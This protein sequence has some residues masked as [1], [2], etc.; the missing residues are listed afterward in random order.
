MRTRRYELLMLKNTCAIA[1]PAMAVLIIL[2]FMLSRYPL[3]DRTRCVEIGNIDNLNKRLSELYIDG[4]TNVS[5]TA[6]ELKYTG[7]N[8]LEDGK[9]KA[10]YYYYVE[11]G[12]LLVMLVNTDKPEA[13]IKNKTVK[14]KIIK[15][16]VVTS[17][18]MNEYAV[19]ND[20]DY[21]LL[22]E[23]CS[24]YVISEPNY[25]YLFSWMLYVIVVSPIIV[26]V[27]ILCYTLV[28][29]FNP[30]FNSQ[31]NQLAVYGE[32]EDIIE[33]L[34]A[35]MT[36]ALKLKKSNVYVTTDYMIVSYLTKTEVIKLDYIKFLSKNIVEKKI[37]LKT[38]EIYRLTMSD[39]EKLFFEVDFGSEELIDAVVESIRGIGD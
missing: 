15:D 11:D 30:R 38:K 31:T 33:D 17:H 25:P 24:E 36:N 22:K 34:N 6:N 18:I 27:I 28:T 4:T 39:P 1:V 29:W 3:I 2:V 8:Y 12:K 13:V 35:Q 14:G 20:I 21:N 10:G 19:K 7:F 9:I 32:I 5:F 37:G 26:C 23:Y 16:N